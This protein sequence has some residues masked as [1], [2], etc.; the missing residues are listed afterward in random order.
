MSKAGPGEEKVVRGKHEFGLGSAD[1]GTDGAHLKR[2]PACGVK[3][4]DRRKEKATLEIW[5][6]L[7]AP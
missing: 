5:T 6:C 4:M 3:R 7:L 2:A 1:C